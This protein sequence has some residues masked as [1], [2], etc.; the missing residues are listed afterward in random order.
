MTYLQQFYVG[1]DVVCI[2]TAQPKDTTLPSELTESAIYKIRWVGPYKTYL[3][4]EYIGIRV[5]GI[6]R[7]TCQIWGDVDPPF[8]ATRF[9]PLVADR[10]GS[11][12]ALLVPGQPIAPAPEDPRR[13]AP[14]KEEEKV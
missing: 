2:S 3:D 13:K 1:Q 10:L 12:R 8:R 6:D 9:R 11:L 14:V 7:G 5:E 4:G